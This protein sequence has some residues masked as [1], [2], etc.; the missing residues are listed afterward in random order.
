MGGR[1]DRLP[2]ITLRRSAT[3][4]YATGRA[5]YSERRVVITLPSANAGKDGMSRDAYHAATACWVLA[6]ELAHIKAGA[7]HAHDEKWA[8][9]YVDAVKARYGQRRDWHRDSDG[10]R[11]ASGYAVDGWVR[12]K[13]MRVWAAQYPLPA[14]PATAAGA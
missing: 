14:L 8:A 3:K 5:Y 2:Q 11:P 7:W 10:P 6:H 9:V 1:A 4:W 13:M 12:P